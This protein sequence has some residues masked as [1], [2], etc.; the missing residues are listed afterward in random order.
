MGHG[1]PGVA[2][3]GHP[4]LELGRLLGELRPAMAGLKW[5]VLPRLA[6]LLAE[7]PS[8]APERMIFVVGCGRSGTT[9]FGRALGGHPGILYL[10]EPRHLWW[11]VDPATDDTDFLGGRGRCYMDERDVTAEVRRR[12]RNAL[13]TVERLAMGR[14]VMEK[15]P[16]HALRLRWLAELFPGARVVH[17]VRDGRQVASRIAR[18]CRTGSYRTA[19]RPDLHPWWGTRQHKLVQ[20]RADA[21]RLLGFDRASTAGWDNVAFGALEWLVSVREVERA[22]TD[23]IGARIDIRTVR[24]E[25]LCEHPARELH[26]ILAWLGLST[27]PQLLETLGSQ[28][29]NVPE[30][31]PCLELPEALKGPFEDEL[32]RLGYL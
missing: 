7:V 13:G 11:A 21:E 15:T 18:L 9:P 22:V 30:G 16:T 26:E 32:G 3:D 6:R 31:P 23:G 28:L 25:R 8:P 19:G 5:A 24:Y 17:L 20:L 12:A 14:S 2:G 27:E 1:G 4:R 10:N 29:R